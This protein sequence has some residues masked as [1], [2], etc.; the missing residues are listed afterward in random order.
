MVAVHLAGQSLRSG[1]CDVALAGGANVI[2]EPNITIAYSQSGMMAPDGR[3][4]FGA[5]A[6]DG[7]VRSDGAAMVVLKRLSTAVADGD[8]IH[9]VIR[10]TAVTNDGRSSGFLATPGR[11]GQEEML[12]RA[13][14][15]AGVDPRTVGY[16]EAHGTGTAA[17]D[18]VELHALGAIV[19]AGRDRGHACLVGSLKSNVGHTEGAAGVAGLIKAALAV[20]HGEIPA[21][22]HVAEP[23]PV[24]P[25]DELGL[26]LCVERR[27]WPET[28]GPRRAGVS[29]FGIAGTNAHA[30]VEA[31]PVPPGEP[32]PTPAAPFV[33]PLSAES[34]EALRALAAAY[35]TRLE[36]APADAGAIGA[37]AASGRS[38]LR[39]RAAVTGADAGALADA[40]ADLAAGETGPEPASPARVVF[41]FPGQGGQ[42]L[43]MGRDLLATAPDFRAAMEQC[44]AVIHAEAGW[45]PIDELGADPSASRLDDIDVVQPL[46]FAV[47]VA[48]AAQWRAWGVEPAAVVGHS[49]GEV[50]AA[51]VAGALTLDDAVA[52]ICRRSGLLRRIAGQGAM[53]VVDLP[54]AEAEAALD[55][56]HD[57]LGVAVVNGPRSVVL[58]GEPDALDEVLASL[59]ANDVFCRRVRVDV[60]SHS[61]QVEPLLDELRAGLTGIR[62]RPTTVT[63]LSTVEAAAIDGE[64]LDADYWA[65]NLRQPV[66]FGAAVE[67]LAADG[68]GLFVELGPHPVLRAAV[69]DVVR[70]RGG[71]TV[72]S[73]RRDEPERAALIS[74]LAEAYSAGVDVDWVAVTGR[75]ARPV[76]L[77]TYPW[78][79]E[80]FWY[81]PARRASFGGTGATSD[82]WLGRRVDLADPDVEVWQGDVSL[83]S[84]P[85]LSGHRIGGVASVPAAALLELARRAAGHPNAVRWADVRFERPL[86]LPDDELVTI[87][88]VRRATGEVTINSDD[89]G[90]WVRHA[91]ARVSPR[92][93]PAIDTPRAVRPTAGEVRADIYDQLA[94]SGVEIGPASRHVVELR[95]DGD[96]HVAHLAGCA[97]DDAVAVLDAAFH[98]AAGAAGEPGSLFV[99]V[100]ARFLELT[101]HRQDGVTAEVVVTS[102]TATYRTV[103]VVVRAADATPVATVDGL[104]LR[105]S[106]GAGGAID[107]CVYEMEWRAAGPLPP[108]RVAAGS[109][110]L[111]V[112]DA[113]GY[114]EAVAAELRSAGARTTVLARGEGCDAVR[115]GA[116]HVDG[117]IFGCGL[118]PFVGE[119]DADALETTLSSCLGPLFD[120][121]RTVSEH[122]RPTPIWVLTSGAQ[123]PGAPGDGPA[124]APAAL[125]GFMRA[126]AEELPDLWGGLLDVDPDADRATSAAAVVDVVLAG[127]AQGPTE[128]EVVLRDGAGLVPRLARTSVPAREA[129]RLAPDATYL[130]TGGFG[131]LGTDVARWLVRNGARRL[132]L[133]GRTELPARR[134]WPGLDPATAIGR[135]AALVKELEGAGVT[136]HTAGVD[137]SDPSAVAGFLDGFAA[138]GWPPIRGV[139]HTAAT[140]GGQLVAQLDAG[141]L[142]ED[143]SAK[144]TG[145]AALAS[146]LP[147][148]DYFV[149]F[150]SMS[151]FAPVAG[152]AA[153][154]A[155]NAA[156]D[157]IAAGRAAAGQPALSVDWGVWADG[158][159]A[160]P[161]G[162]SKE[163]A[164]RLYASQGIGEIAPDEGL[165][166]LAALLGAGA[167]SVTVVRA[168]WAVFAEARPGRA[169][170]IVTDLVELEPEPEDR[171]P[172]ATTSA[173]LLERLAAARPRDR[174]EIAE[175]EVRRILGAVLRLAEARIDRTRP[176]GALGLDSLMAVELRNRLEAEL[177]RRLS[178]TLAW[179]FP[180]VKELAAYVVGLVESEETD[181]EDTA[182]PEAAEARHVAVAVEEMSDDDALLALMGDGR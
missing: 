37:T 86:V 32:F 11:A 12:R 42:W 28:A 44:D 5:A 164:R 68:C 174:V 50:A 113:G 23:N 90:T 162:A 163:A 118:G 149:L 124:V 83:A 31:A 10:G 27:A 30:V 87:Q 65:R 114:G 43:G 51:H 8:R 161:G 146:G 72:A 48:L 84:R 137:V 35:R 159:G 138:D 144:V 79:R 6:A 92:P 171:G 151:A 116:D 130:V 117:V 58:S 97:A 26:E 177:G 104:R 55:G 78:Q 168:D 176:F 107:R 133:L 105:R 3:C 135:R 128:R 148:L 7:Y 157:A 140:L 100:A 82:P 181:R 76:D 129:L 158:D 69:D 134:E 152:Q 85:E 20:E 173:I 156:L 41:V 18:P 75:P 155:A 160:A 111:V 112:P 95:S 9:A 71:R 179:N 33:L 139:F 19:G 2:L 147:D 106:G 29:S 109:H 70:A 165:E 132:V 47:E 125:W 14:A 64:R 167:T 25:W 172:S 123:G 22:I 21:S 16:V 108:R 81:E 121:V 145:A 73:T 53:A 39:H 101:G 131:T 94:G 126:V 170:A 153:Y 38:H 89:G 182:A 60:A 54:A 66:Q 154:A 15:D 119:R 136:V 141:R 93:G 175:A 36:Q 57:R 56:F 4:K 13:Y 98:A 143:M 40:L 24:I 142:L 77:P 169:A 103:D 96:V 102:R 180:T 67:Q 59:E 99:P 110:W 88:V 62:P 120:A 80:R 166:M 63:M 115:T 52:V 178:A 17:G 34:T 1:E 127:D 45:S 46:L 91:G 49:M 122:D 150:S 74:G 61:P